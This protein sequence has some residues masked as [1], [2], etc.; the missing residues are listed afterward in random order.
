[1]RVCVYVYVCVYTLTSLH[2]SGLSGLWCWLRLSYQVSLLPHGRPIHYSLS[3]EKSG[4]KIRNHGPKELGSI[5]CTFL[6][7]ST[8]RP[9]AVCLTRWKT[10]IYNVSWTLWWLKTKN[11]LRSYIYVTVLLTQVVLTGSDFG[12][13]LCHDF[14]FTRYPWIVDNAVMDA[15]LIFKICH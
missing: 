14:N 7:R 4:R 13:L 15:G 1:M 11:D 10:A 9:I 3:W 5:D 6:S 2:S 12:C 8:R